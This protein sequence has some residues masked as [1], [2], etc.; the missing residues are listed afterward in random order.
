MLFGIEI[1]LGA[2]VQAGVQLNGLESQFIDRRVDAIRPRRIPV[3]APRLTARFGQPSRSGAALLYYGFH[4]YD[5]VA[6]TLRFSIVAQLGKSPYRVLHIL[7]A[8]FAA[9]AFSVRWTAAVGIERRGEYH[10]PGNAQ[11][12]GQKTGS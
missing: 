11:G 12:Q 4:G 10:G 6:A 5:V 2:E 3:G 7:V 8:T 1:F 9:F